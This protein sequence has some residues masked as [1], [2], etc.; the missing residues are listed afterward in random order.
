MSTR[1][2]RLNQQDRKE[3]ER[4][5]SVINSDNSD[6][7]TLR[8]FGKLMTIADSYDYQPEDN[9]SV[10]LDLTIYQSY[11]LKHQA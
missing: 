4:L 11:G 3:A 9:D 6:N 10:D 5:I 8:R 1:L 7:E 2:N